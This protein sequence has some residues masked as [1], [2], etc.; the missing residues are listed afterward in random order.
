MIPG[1]SVLLFPCPQKM[2][3][4][5]D[6]VPLP[7]TT[8]S[9]GHD[10][11]RPRDLHVDAEG[12]AVSRTS[13][14]ETSRH[15]LLSGRA[16]AADHTNNSMSDATYVCHVVEACA[17]GNEDVAL[18]MSD[19]RLCHAKLSRPIEL[20]PLEQRRWPQWTSWA[21]RHGSVR[22]LTFSPAH[23]ALLTLEVSLVRSPLLRHG[24]HSF[25]LAALP[26]TPCA[27][28]NSCSVPSKLQEPITPPAD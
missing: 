15:G 19:G 4:E 17:M 2:F 21:S 26:A 27:L 23:D 7:T 20:I 28:S 8:P 14:V 13:G 11:S 12:V 16:A 24:L 6:L 22:Q 18:A 3:D 1:S 25:L 10:T 5:A 9:D